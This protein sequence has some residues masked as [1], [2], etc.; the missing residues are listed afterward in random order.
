MR[1]L[2]MTSDTEKQ[3][4]YHTKNQCMTQFY[5]IDSK[6]LKD[7]LHQ[8]NSS[9]C[10]LDILQK[11]LTGDS[12]E[13]FTDCELVS[14]VRCL[15]TGK[16]GQSWLKSGLSSLSMKVKKWK[17]CFSIVNWLLNTNQLLWCLSVRFQQHH[18]TETALTNMVNDISL[19]TS[20]DKIDLILFLFLLD[21]S[22][23][24]DPADHNMYST[25]WRTGG[26]ELVQILEDRNYFVSMGNFTSEQTKITCS[27]PQ[28][29]IL[30]LLLFKICM[31]PWLR[32]TK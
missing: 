3:L 7:I 5:P 22:A 11:G 28:G 16:K 18:S 17:S 10:C 20:N 26:S 32:T 29:S 4:A 31:L 21:I 30:G 1:L 12:V 13:S 6:N 25:N 15:S 24:F 19:N 2:E 23:A 27:V 14:Y 9:S 8:L